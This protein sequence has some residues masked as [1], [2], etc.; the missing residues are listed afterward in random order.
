MKS[1]SNKV[2]TISVVVVAALALC[3]CSLLVLGGAG[4]YYF[5]GQ[6]GQQVPILAIGATPT[7]RVV[8]PTT[9]PPL[10]LAIP[11]VA[12]PSA[13]PTSSIAPTPEPGA[14]PTAPAGET[15]LSTLKLLE[16]MV[17]PENDLIELARRLQ[18]VQEITEVFPP[19][20][21]PF[22][23]G[24]QKLFWASNSD[25]NRYFQ[26]QA[27]LEYITQHVYFWVEDGVDFVPDEMELLVDTF[28]EQIYPT[29]R[30]F[31]GSERTPGID[32]D[33]HLYILY[34]TGLGKNLAGYFS[35]ANADPPEVRRYSNAVEMFLFS[36]QTVNLGEPF[37][38]NVLAH[39]FQHMI[40]WSRDRNEETWM[41]EGFSELAAL[42]NGFYNSGFDGAY[43]VDPDVQLNDWPDSDGFSA[44]HYGS[45]FLFLSYFLDRFGEE[46]TKTL[47]GDPENGM[48]SIDSVLSQLNI[49][50][51]GSGQIITA[52]DLFLDWV[53]TSYINDPT[54]GDGRYVY[55][56]HP[57]APA[58]QPTEIFS[59]CPFTK[60][61]RA[62]HQYA[63]DYVLLNC[64]GQYT[65][66]F[67]GSIQTQVVPEDPYSG[68]Y[69]FWSNRG[70]ESDMKLTRSFD[71][72][73]V[74]GPLTLRY[75][76]WYD[77]EQG[78]DY[79]YLAAS[80]DGEAWEILRT[81]SS[82]NTDPNGSN[83][84]WGYSGASGGAT[85]EWIEEQVD[86]SR[87][88][89]RRVQLRFEYVTDTA[90]NREGFLLDDVEVPE[91]GYFEDFER[92]TGGWDGEGWVRMDNI[93]PQNWRLAVIRK[94][95]ESTS[96]E[97]VPMNSDLSATI[98]IEIGDDF[99]EVI[100]VVTANT[101]FTRQ[102]TAYQFT[103]KP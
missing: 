53:I 54:V 79:V 89:G 82:T 44:P 87:F 30:A 31:F 45:A 85:P 27:T 40:H 102:P 13:V 37:A 73:G 86:L 88:A 26:V 93:L 35:S 24:D 50:D 41:N 103:V 63:V 67:E 4:L 56:N 23:I 5:A 75:K 34:A 98:S 7:P 11:T 65:L 77:I 69:V 38:Y 3:F 94:G 29:N 62:V 2:F 36:S 33:P 66:T 78:Y 12:R 83:L 47:V 59:I 99:D 18:G 6:A 68:Q 70:D 61:V 81:P 19:P 39:E 55:I 60:K 100:L 17:I 21:R 95:P 43:V 1:S 92:D 14:P 96:V 97:Y 46:A 76:A 80:E 84:G 10:E 74:E 9:L 25:E 20:A 48:R 22:R 28:E 90:V 57:A 51:P 58:P 91:I 49:T 101:R 32:S 8:R 64:P 71:F 52:D 72:T 42:L 15:S 16:N